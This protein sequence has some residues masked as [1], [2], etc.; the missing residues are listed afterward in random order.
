MRRGGG[1]GL[2][3]GGRP[4][5]AA[6]AGAPPGSRTDWVIP[7]LSG[8]RSRPS[9]T[10]SDRAIRD[11]GERFIALGQAGRESVVADR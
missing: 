11:E 7:H 5:R 8:L 10:R 3:K 4:H 6:G 9:Q 1:W 2:R